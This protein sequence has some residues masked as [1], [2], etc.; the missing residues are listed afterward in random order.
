MIRF[1]GKTRKQVIVNVNKIS[2]ICPGWD[3]RSYEH[4]SVSS[5]RTIGNE[6]FLYSFK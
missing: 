1:R 2:F 4:C 6:Y 5:H 3:R